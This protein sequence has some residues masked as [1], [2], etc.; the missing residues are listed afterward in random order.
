MGLPRLSRFTVH[1]QPVVDAITGLPRSLEA[2]VRWE[3][4]EFGKV[5]PDQFIPLAEEKGLIVALG[6]QVLTK[7]LRAARHCRNHGWPVLMAV[8]LSRRELI[9]PDFCEEIMKRIETEGLAPEHLILEVTEREAFIQDPH[10]RRNLEMLAACGIRLS[11]DDFGAG[12]SSFEVLTEL[13]FHQLKLNMGLVRRSE[14]SRCARIIEAVVELGQKLGL[15]IVGEGVETQTQREFLTGLG[16]GK[17]QGY[18]YS[19][20]LDDEGLAGYLAQ[21][22]RSCAAAA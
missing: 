7:S 6:R 5:S 15:E 10:C 3:D 8:N 19:R 1:Y 13:S 20:P 16:V 9:Q 14:Q 2:L 11:L 21:F 18:L 17:L 22:P 12:F 4:A